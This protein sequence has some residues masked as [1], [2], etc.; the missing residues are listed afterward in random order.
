M[1]HDFSNKAVLI[2][3]AMVVA[4]GQG[5]GAAQ[6]AQLPAAGT[7]SLDPVHTFVYFVAK[8]VVVGRVRGRFVKTTGTINV[9]KDPAAC[10]VE[11]SFEASSVDT[12]NVNRD[13]DL[14]SP[15][16]FDAAQFPTITYRGRGIRRAGDGWVMDGS[17]TI[18]DV[19]KVVPL[20]FVFGGTAAAQTGKPMRV[21]FR[22]T[23]ATKRAEFGMTK[24]LLEEI[25]IESRDP[26]VWIEIE[27]EALA[28]KDSQ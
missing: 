23:A 21:A 10:S 11:A 27:A 1:R 20:K 16:F 2:A 4:L 17:L 18:R 9:A 13:K 5:P 12:Q 19:T 14:R 8:H 7:Y 24:D 6:E 3:A 25:G 22:A 26:D 15:N 28:S